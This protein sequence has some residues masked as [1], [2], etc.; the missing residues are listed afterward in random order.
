MQSLAW[1]L[2]NWWYKSVYIASSAYICV[3]TPWHC[4]GRSLICRV[5][6]KGLNTEPCGTPIFRFILLHTGSRTLAQR[7]LFDK[8]KK[9]CDS[10]C[11]KLNRADGEPRQQEIVV[12]GIEC[13]AQIQSYSSNLSTF[14]K[15]YRRSGWFHL[16]YRMHGSSLVEWFGLNPNCILCKPKVSVLMNAVS[17][18]ITTFQW[19]L[20]VLAVYL[21]ACNSRQSPD[22]KV[23]VIIAHFQSSG[24]ELCSIDKLIK[25]VMRGIMSLDSTNTLSK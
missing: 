15:W 11:K 4:F 25:R 16:L 2:L 21:L 19:L 1:L 6:N 17:C 20:G 5:D 8:M 7:S 13:C 12:D 23:G 14:I 9:F 22:W 3:S 24:K 10:P 18:S